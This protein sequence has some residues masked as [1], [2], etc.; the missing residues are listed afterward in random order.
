MAEIKDLAEYELGEA[1]LG[2]TSEGLDE[3]RTKYAIYDEAGANRYFRILTA[4]GREKA[5]VV[6]LRDAELERVR[7][8][9]DSKL[10][11]IAEKADFFEGM[12]RDYFERERAKN[13]KY[14][15]ATPWGKVTQRTTKTP[16]WKDESATLEWLERNRADLVKVDKSIKKAELKKAMVL[17]GSSYVDE[18]SGEVVP[19]VSIEERTTTNVK[20]GE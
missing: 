12:V 6:A 11:V 14:K 5:E 2:R 4:L 19:G 3:Y 9:Y 8:F 15:L 7:A 18:S 16:I 13:P 10:D 20:A 17:S 1:L